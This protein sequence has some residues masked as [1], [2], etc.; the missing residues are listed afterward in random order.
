MENQVEIDLS[1]LKFTSVNKMNLGKIS[2]KE[3]FRG[4]HIR[5]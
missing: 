2:K 5:R 3:G 4:L 1:Q